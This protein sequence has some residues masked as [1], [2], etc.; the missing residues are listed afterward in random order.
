M[1]DPDGLPRLCRG[2]LR[3]VFSLSVIHQLRLCAE[4]VCQRREQDPAHAD[5]LY[6]R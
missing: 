3:L 1:L 4:L 5:L 6:I 2:G